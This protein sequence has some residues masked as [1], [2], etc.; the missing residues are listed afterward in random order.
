M[1]DSIRYAQ[2]IQQAIL[3]L[4]GQIDSSFAD[5]FVLYRPKDIVSGDFYWMMQ[6]ENYT[7]FAV[8]DCT[9]HGVPGAFMSLVGTTVLDDIITKERVFEPADI[10]EHL[11]QSVQFI[12]KQNERSDNQDGMDVCLC[13]FERISAGSEEEN[14]DVRITF[15]GAKRPLYYI[16][17]E[18]EDIELEQLKG[19]RKSIGGAQRG[20]KRFASQNLILGPGSILYFTT[21]GLVDQHNDKGRKIGSPRFERKLAQIAHL[22]MAEQGQKIERMLDK[23]QNTQIQ[24]DDITVIGIKL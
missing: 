8:V 20:D 12:L 19:T 9:G 13:R 4:E 15:A 2:T 7:F 6:H 5:Y 10:L 1:T 18:E 17:A 24:R 23:Y 11:N 22:P 3:P 21:D 14:G 16:D